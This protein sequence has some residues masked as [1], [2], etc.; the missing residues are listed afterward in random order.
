LGSQFE[1]FRLVS[2]DGVPL[3]ARTDFPTLMHTCQAVKSC[4]RD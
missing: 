3:S 1:H 4:G 2:A